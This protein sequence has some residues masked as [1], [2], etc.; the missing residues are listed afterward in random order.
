MR[1]RIASIALAI[2]LALGGSVT[3]SA[4]NRP[5]YTEIPNDDAEMAA[6]QAKARATL[7]EFW[8]KL[9]SPG[10]REDGFALKV[11]LP[12]DA[13]S[14]EHIWVSAIERRDGKIF[15]RI[16]NRPVNLKNVRQGQRIE[17][18]E[19]QISDWT[20]RRDGKIVGNFTM[21]PLLK[22]MPPADAERY[23]AMLADP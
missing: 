11:G 7:A 13:K 21:R 17:I 3:V 1:N 23:R 18:A 2:L 15:G 9:A 12:I 19:S 16:S 22:L 5:G 20:Y 10:P 8:S 6:A 14:G 4:Q